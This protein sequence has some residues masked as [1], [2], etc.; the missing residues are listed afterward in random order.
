MLV[1]WGIVDVFVRSEYG[2][3]CIDVGGWCEY[4]VCVGFD[5]LVVVGSCD[6][7]EVN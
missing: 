2:F 5:G 6:V 3:F 1:L 7:G 4:E